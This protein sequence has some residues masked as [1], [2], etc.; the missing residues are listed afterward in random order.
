MTK[1]WPWTIFADSE[2]LYLDHFGSPKS[3]SYLDADEECTSSLLSTIFHPPRPPTEDASGETASSAERTLAPPEL[4][5]SVSACSR[6][7]FAGPDKEGV[8]FNR[9]G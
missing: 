2:K 6:S 5:T 3:S 4:T 1:F 9:T 8:N 7:L